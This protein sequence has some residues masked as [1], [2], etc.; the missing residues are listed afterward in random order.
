MCCSRDTAKSKYCHEKRRIDTNEN[1]KRKKDQKERYDGLMVKGLVLNSEV[2]GSGPFP[3]CS[4]RSAVLM[5]SHASKS[6]QHFFL[7]D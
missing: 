7:L 1:P 2:L 5:Q 4:E 3:S 6:N